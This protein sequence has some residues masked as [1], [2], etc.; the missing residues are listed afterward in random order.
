MSWIVK[1][2]LHHVENWGN[3]LAAK[4]NMFELFPYSFHHIFLKLYLITSTE[5]CVKVSFLDF[6]EN[7]MLFHNGING[8]SVRTG[9]SI[10]T[11][12]LFLLTFKA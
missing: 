9:R 2:N 4:I 1:K 6:E 12:Y 3:G 11:V 5:K 7:I 8:S 10:V